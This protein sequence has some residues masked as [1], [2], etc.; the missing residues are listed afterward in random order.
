MALENDEDIERIF[1]LKKLPAI[2]GSSEFIQTI[3]ERF[4]AA[5]V[6]TEVPESK[7]L[8]PISIESIKAAV[9]AYYGVEDADLFAVRRGIT[10]E[11]R[12]VAVYLAR[13]L[14]GENLQEIARQFQ[15]KSYSTAGS[16]VGCVKAKIQDDAN[17]AQRLARIREML[18]IGQRKT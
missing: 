16:V 9:T 17:F 14:R 1:S 5:K 7:M 15:I 18:E 12:N 8:T 2:L 10:N 6:S 11:P 3:N 13:T 4:F